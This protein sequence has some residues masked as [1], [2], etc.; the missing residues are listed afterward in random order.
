MDAK[1]ADDHSVAVRVV[2]FR[3]NCWRATLPCTN[4]LRKSNLSPSGCK[5]S[6]RIITA[7]LRKERAILETR[8]S[9]HANI[10]SEQ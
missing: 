7:E 2:E 8:L 9:S 3:N 4:L 10:K 1:A 6:R 5:N